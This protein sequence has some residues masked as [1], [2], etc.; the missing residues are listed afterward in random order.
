[1]SGGSAVKQYLLDNGFKYNGSCHCGGAYT[2]NFE[3]KTVAGSVRIR[4]RAN[5]FLLSMPG[6]EFKKHPI[7]E[8]KTKIN[9]VKGFIEALITEQ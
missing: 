2:Q 3:Q 7:S 8:I 6:S 4:A 5:N 9:E 1:M